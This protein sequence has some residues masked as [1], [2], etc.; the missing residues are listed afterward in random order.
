MSWIKLKEAVYVLIALVFL[1][2]IIEFS[3]FGLYLTT[4][5]KYFSNF[6][7][8]HPRNDCPTAANNKATIPLKIAIFGGSSAAGYASPIGFSKLL[9]SSDFTNKEVTITN[10]A[11]PGEPFSD[12]QAE[13]VKK[14]MSNYDVIIIYSGHNEIWTQIYRRNYTTHFPDGMV[15]GNPDLV[16]K[17]RIRKLNLLNLES[18]ILGQVYNW[19]INNSRIYHFFSRAFFKIK[20]ITVKTNS[21]KDIESIDIYPKKFIYNKTFLTHHERE[22]ILDLYKKNI[23]E[24]SGS[25][26]DNQKMILSTVISNDL[27][28]PI[29]D[30]DTGENSDRLEYINKK[31]KEAFVSSGADRSNII[32]QIIY[33]L[34]EG[35]TKYYLNGFLCLESNIEYSSKCYVDFIKARKHDAFPLRVIPEI[36]SFIRTLNKKNVIIVDPAKDIINRA[37]NIKK[38]KDFFVDFQHPSQ[39]GH[40]IIAENILLGLFPNQKISRN[41]I[42]EL[43]GIKFVENGNTKSIRPKHINHCFNSYDT[44]L[45][46]LENFTERQPVEF[47][48]D[49]YKQRSV[50]ALKALSKD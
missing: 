38:Y 16:H 21:K 37:E 35:A 9:C 19:T 23:E 24:I 27:F 12:F 3:M 43:C 50:N 34:P 11:A 17:N 10:Y 45:Q 22:N 28:L 5:S 13:K 4:G 46:W 33:N 36:N 29:A 40:A 8:L 41:Y 7:E 2:A 15:A 32:K 14:V 1:I 20:N 49:F 47:Q 44:N 31:L 25:L 39:L 30:V 26:R 42:E 6:N 18:S 48:F